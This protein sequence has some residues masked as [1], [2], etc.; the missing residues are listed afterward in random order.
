MEPTTTAHDLKTSKNDLKTPPVD[1]TAQ[2]DIDNGST[3]TYIDPAQE[4]KVLRKFDLFAIGLFGLF[5]AMAN[6]DRSN[7]GNAQIAGMPED[8][9]LVGNQFGTAT[10]LLYA[11][12]VPFEAPA[13]LLP[14]KI[15]PKYLM[16]FCAF[17]WGLT[18]LDMGFIQ[19]YKGLYACRL[20]I[21]L[22]ESGLIPSINVYIAMVYKKSERGKRSAVV[23]AF[24]AFS[25]AFGGVLAFGLTQIR[26]PNGFEGWRWLFIVE[27]LL[28]LLLVPLSYTLFP[29]TPTT[30]WFLTAPEK[31]LMTLRYTQK[32]SHFALDEP[33]AWTAVVSAFTDTKWYAFWI[34][35]FCCDVSL[36]GLT[37]FMPATVQGLGYS[38]V[39]ANL[40]TVPVFMVSLVVFLV[41][42]WASDRTGLRGPYLLGALTSLIIGYAILISVENLKARYFACFM[43]AIG[44]Y[45]TTGLSLMWL[46]D[47]AAGHYKRAT[48]VG[49][50]LTLGNTAGVAVGQIFTTESK[51]RYIE[52]MSIALGLACVSMAM[53][54]AL[55]GGMAY[56]NGKRA[57]AIKK[58]EEEGKE[59]E[60]RPGKGDYDV[61]FRYSL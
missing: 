58:A 19:D 12:Y 22:F 40:M 6:L 56:V 45:P 24:N 14:K 26:G 60:P 7:L 8:I 27:G 53:V 49:M 50:T 51:P 38:S 46:Q 10:T 13:A 55:M 36:Y 18:T 44:I 35:Q 3:T 4:R 2:I 33:F 21:G 30:A 48:M 11:T 31:H 61:H 28:T 9:G 42:A 39:Q 59:I 15:S 57:K 23:F 20:L 25:S 32:T 17:S 16:S 37:T 43:A 47:N 52:G 34:Y 5:Y 41:I 1:E 54:V 29:A